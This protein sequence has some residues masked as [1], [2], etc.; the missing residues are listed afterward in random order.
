M[1]A[2]VWLPNPQVRQH[3]PVHWR[4][5]AVADIGEQPGRQQGTHLRT[6]YPG[7]RNPAWRRGGLLGGGDIRA[8]LEG[9]GGQEGK[10]GRSCGALR[11][12]ALTLGPCL[13]F[14]KRQQEK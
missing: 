9:L 3:R 2:D 13:G 10:S 7:E 14:Y 4:G 8:R 12:L 1:L 11:W 6:V 5:G